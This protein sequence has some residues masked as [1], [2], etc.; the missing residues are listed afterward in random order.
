MTYPFGLGERLG[1]IFAASKTA[2]TIYV[3][4]EAAGFAD[5]TSWSD[6]FT[7]IQ[8]AIDS[9]EGVIQHTYTIT[10]RAGTKKTGTADA[11][12]A[13]K[14][15]D[16]GEFPAA[17]TWAGRRVFNITDGT[18][19][20]V[21][22]RDSDDQL[23]I[24][25]T[26]GAALDLFDT[27]NEDYVIEPTPYREQVELSS[28]PATYLPHLILGSLTIEAEHYW[29]GDCDAQANAGE[30]L[31]ALADFSNVELGDR[32]WVLDLNGADDRAIDYEVGTVDDISQIAS[33]IVR[34]TLTKTPTT[35]W[36][37][38]IVKTESSG[39]DNGTTPGIAR[40]Y[41]FY[42]KTID[43]VNINGFYATLT[44]SFILRGENSR[45]ITFYCSISDRNSR[46][47]N[48]DYSTISVEYVA[49]ERS[50][51]YSGDAAK[52]GALRMLWCA[53]DHDG[54]YATNVE[55]GYLLF[56][57][58]IIV[59]GSAAVR[60]DQVGF[61][62]IH[63]STIT[64]GCDTG[65]MVGHNSSIMTYASTNN[66]VIPEDPAATVEGAYIG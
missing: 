54:S 56:Q 51:G 32:V 17:T 16:T 18:W 3:D 53:I 66:G 50:G 60:V 6:A 22:A 4:K 5:G 38:V 61:A 64:N 52:S 30:I 36:K 19:G 37:Y 12:V 58:G 33:H 48:A 59:D 44:S 39:S 24:V 40:E 9:L 20:V 31:D 29:Q 34:T 1:R 65:L 15:H 13:N 55:H 23:S 11:H 43:N 42:L 21:S 41:C 10:V 62:Y 8:A 45:A 35:N 14:L 2:K 25:N 63:S 49:R 26:A 47:I 27:G 57:Y 28:D 7:T 46:G